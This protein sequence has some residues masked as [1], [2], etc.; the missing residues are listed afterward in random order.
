MT[1]AKLAFFKLIVRDLVR[2]TAFYEAA[3]D[4]HQVD[5]FDTPEFEEAMFRQGDDPFLLMLLRYKDG[6]TFGDSAAHGP[7]GFVTENL[8]AALAKAIT[9]G[10]TLKLEPMEAGSTRVAFLDDPE[11]HEIEVIQ[12]I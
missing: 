10:A 1:A 11:G 6:R 5:G 12:F 9:A 3:F 4:F 2:M 7:T 8:D